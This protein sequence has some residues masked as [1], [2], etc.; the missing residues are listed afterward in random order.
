MSNDSTYSRR[1]LL[2]LS[3]VAAVTAI[4]AGCTDEGPGEEDDGV[5]DDDVTDDETEEDNGVTDD[6]TEED[7]A[8]DE[9]EDEDDETVDEDEEEDENGNGDGESIEP[10]TTIVFDGQTE[11]WEGLEPDAIEGETNPTL[12]LE[13]DEEYEIGWEEGD[14]AAHNIEIWDEDE[15]VVDDLETDVT[16]D[17]DEDQFLEF[18]ASEEMAYYVCNPHRTT[19]IGEID[20]E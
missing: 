16:D 18:T 14:G 6:E 5:P 20:V 12:V 11:G 10:G 7:D 17:P 4:V 8:D 9:E 19:M 2:R 3:G 15:V 1:R 13:A